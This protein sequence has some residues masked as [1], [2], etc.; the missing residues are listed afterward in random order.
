MLFPAVPAWTALVAVVAGLIFLGLGLRDLLAGRQ[1]ARDWRT[2]PGRVVASRLDD[3]HVRAKVA[4]QHE[5][6]EIQFWN[7]YSSTTV[8][9]PVGREVQVLVD[10]ADPS[11]AVVSRGLVG[12]GTA[13]IAFCAFG[14]LATVIGLV[15]V[16]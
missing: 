7:R 8:T 1:R 12:S 16:L 9:D 3:G 11:R 5:G 2:V 13:G 14:V 4:F 15:L 10:P 6:R